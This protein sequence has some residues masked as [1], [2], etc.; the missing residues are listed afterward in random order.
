MKTTLKLTSF[1]QQL[2]SL[3]EKKS[4]R[5]LM[6]SITLRAALLILFAFALAAFGGWERLAA[7]AADVV[8]GGYIQ[9]QPNA[10][11]LT[12]GTTQ[13]LRAAVLNPVGFE[14]P[15]RK[16]TWTSS[17]PAIANVNSTGLVTSIAPGTVTITAK[18]GA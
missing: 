10:V 1:T 4:L 8:P 5:N 3:S 15:N 7:F 12:Q 2:K 17:N 11:T 9:I 18:S 13:Q 14:L 16:V 6:R